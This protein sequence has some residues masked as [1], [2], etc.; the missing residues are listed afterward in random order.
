MEQLVTD[1]PFTEYW[2]LV[3]LASGV[4]R[5]KKFLHFDGLGDGERLKLPPRSYQIPQLTLRLLLVVDEGDVKDRAD[6]KMLILGSRP[7]LLGG[8]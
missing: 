5:G 4:W 1:H 2:I 8:S 3:L 7:P 6:G